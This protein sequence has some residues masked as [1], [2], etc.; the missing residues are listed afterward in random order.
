MICGGT[1]IRDGA[2][3]EEHVIVGRPEQGYAVGLVYPGAGADTVIGA[4]AVIRSGAVIYA[5]ADRLVTLPGRA[6]V[7]QRR[8]RARLHCVQ[9]GRNAPGQ[10]RRHQPRDVVPRDE[11]EPGQLAVREHDLL[12]LRRR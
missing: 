6:S 3:V 10:Q 1:R 9:A 2:R 4:G 12:D 5:G 11:R 7:L 8:D